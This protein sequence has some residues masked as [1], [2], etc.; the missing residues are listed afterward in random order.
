MRILGAAL[1]VLGLL[2]LIFGGIPYKKTETIAEIGGLKMRA[3]ENRQMSV[4]PLVS[5]FAIL[6]G[7]ALWFSAKS[8]PSS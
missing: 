3:T 6:V 8:R 1:V 7:A 5:G 2:G 4:P